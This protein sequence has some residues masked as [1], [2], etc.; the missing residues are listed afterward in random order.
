MYVVIL[1]F[2]VCGLITYIV[3]SIILVNKYSTSVCDLIIVLVHNICMY[4]VYFKATLVFTKI[5]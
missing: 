2:S 5:Y 1:D 3:S 4:L